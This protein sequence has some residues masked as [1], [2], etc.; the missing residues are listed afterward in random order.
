[1]QNDDGYYWTVQLEEQ[2]NNI[3]NEDEHGK[4]RIDD[5]GKAENAVQS[6][7][8]KLEGWQHE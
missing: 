7:A 6:K 3:F 4:T 1:M 5:S 2:F 8:C